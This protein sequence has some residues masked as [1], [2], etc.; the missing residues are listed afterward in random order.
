MVQL[1]QL[2]IINI[3]FIPILNEKHDY[4][5]DKEFVLKYS[6]EIKMI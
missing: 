4:T 1:L 6:Q 3:Y 2:I 5:R